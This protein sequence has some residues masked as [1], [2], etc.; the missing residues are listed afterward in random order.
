MPLLKLYDSLSP[1]LAR[2]LKAAKN[3][4]P[5][6]A[7]MGQTIKSLAQRAFTDGAL[8]PATWAARKVEPKDGHLLLQESTMLRKSIDVTSC[9]ASQVTIGSDRPYAAAHQLGNPAGNLPARPFFPFLPN[10]QLTPPA[11]KNVESIIR[12]A[13]KG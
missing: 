7:R 2:R 8:R 12:G 4:Q 1:D 11:A 10:G 9:T 6:L 5:I 13:L 3:P